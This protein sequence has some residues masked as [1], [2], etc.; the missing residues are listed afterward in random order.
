[1]K[2]VRER[3]ADKEK[4]KRKAIEK[5]NRKIQRLNEKVAERKRRFMVEWT[6]MVNK[7]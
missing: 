6:K 4:A 7:Q 1:M 3:I 2:S 5:E